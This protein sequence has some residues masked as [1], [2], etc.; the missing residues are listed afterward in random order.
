MEHGPLAWGLL[1]ALRRQS[2]LRR[3]EH[4]VGCNCLIVD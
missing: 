2:A 3:G 4:I 1:K